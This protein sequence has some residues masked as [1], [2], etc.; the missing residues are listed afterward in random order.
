MD[1]G[2]ITQTLKDSYEVEI[3]HPATGDGGWFIELAAPHHSG[4]QQKVNAILDRAKKRKVSTAG[5]DEKDGVDLL[6]ARILGWRGLTN[7]VDP[8]EYTEEAA[9]AIL[10][11][12]KSFWVRQQ[13]IEALGDTTRPFTN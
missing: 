3:V 11:N 12:P 9:R 7:G 6:M 8:V 5:Q 13:L 1:F 2:A 10:S 4:A